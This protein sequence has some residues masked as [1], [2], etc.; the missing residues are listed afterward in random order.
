MPACKSRALLRFLRRRKIGVKVLRGNQCI[1]P[2]SLADSDG[3][4]DEKRNCVTFYEGGAAIHNATVLL[5]GTLVY[6]N[7]LHVKRDLHIC[8]LNAH[9]RSIF[10]TQRSG[11]TVSLP[12]HEEIAIEGRARYT[13][14]CAHKHRRYNS[15][16]REKE[17][18]KNMPYAVVALLR[19]HLGFIYTLPRATSRVFDIVITKS[20]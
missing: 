1:F 9:V 6:I 20:R 7:A 4:N 16:L 8:K 13:H 10:P 19:I 17:P 14:S 3:V 18:D 11:C 2:R 15:R 12:D 5:C